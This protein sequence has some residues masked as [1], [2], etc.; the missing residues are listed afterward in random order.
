TGLPKPPAFVRER[1][2]AKKICES[3]IQP[4]RKMLIVE[5][6]DQVYVFVVDGQVRKFAFDIRSYSDVVFFLPVNEEPGRVSMSLL[7]PVFRNELRK[8]FFVLHRENQNRDAGIQP[9][10]AIERLGV[11]ETNLLEL[12]RDAAG[13][14]F[15]VVA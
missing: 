6:H 2:T 11:K 4:Y 15:A 1:R 10:A 14:L 5:V 12:V 3:F 8:R 13:R 7:G 9:Q